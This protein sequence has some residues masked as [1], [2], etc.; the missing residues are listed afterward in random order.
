MAI[1]NTT[2]RHAKWQAI[3]AEQEQSGLSQKEFCNTHNLVL[4][5]FVYYRGTLKAKKPVIAE[6]SFA[7]VHIKKAEHDVVS[8][9]KIILPNGFQCIA[10]SSIDC[11]RLK[12]LMGA[13]LS[14]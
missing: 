2:T 9:I 3:I 1:E 6:P 13:L 11:V 5:Q 10:P 4:S 7:P 14:C 8:D 12:N